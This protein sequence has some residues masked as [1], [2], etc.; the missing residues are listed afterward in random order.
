MSGVVRVTRPTPECWVS[1]QGTRSIG[2]WMGPRAGLNASEKSILL[3]QGDEPQF[4][5]GVQ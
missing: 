1:A 2:G 4:L 5:E 3:I